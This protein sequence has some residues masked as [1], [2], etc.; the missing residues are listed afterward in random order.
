M[1]SPAIAERE[2]RY[3]FKTWN[4]PI[5]LTFFDL[6]QTGSVSEPTKIT[7]VS[8]EG[9]LIQYDSGIFG[10]R[11]LWD[12]PVQPKT[13]EEAMLA[14]AK[15]YGGL[16]SD[17]NKK[18]WTFY[19]TRIKRDPL[20]IESL[21]DTKTIVRLLAERYGL[22][23]TAQDDFRQTLTRLVNFPVPQIVFKTTPPSQISSE[24]ISQ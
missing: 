15:R 9:M 23:Q 20:I 14:A 12:L 10:I 21:E 7:L 16:I 24:E 2:R 19:F 18:E 5:G 4:G 8:T 11:G 22:D 6:M 1:S 13:P 3:S 17:K